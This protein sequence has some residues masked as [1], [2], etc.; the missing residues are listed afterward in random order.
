MTKIED[1]VDKNNLNI[2]SDETIEHLSRIDD[3]NERAREKVAKILT[4]KVPNYVDP[5]VD[6]VQI[7]S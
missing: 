2:H 7:T 5:R 1:L 4:R 3:I 6:S